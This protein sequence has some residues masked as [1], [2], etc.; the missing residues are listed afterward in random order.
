M[1]T[2]TQTPA[3]PVAHA[4]EPRAPRAPRRR[5]GPVVARVAEPVLAVLAVLAAAFAFAPFFAGWTWLVPVLVAAGAGGTLGWFVT[6]QRWP[7]WTLAPVGVAA[8][9]VGSLYGLHAS[10]TLY[11]LP[12]PAALR[13]TVDGVLSGWARMLTVALPADV[14]PETLALPVALVLVC[15]Y[16]AVLLTLRTRLVVGVAMPALVVL[17]GALALTAGRSAWALAATVGFLGAVLV[18]VLVRAN[19][20]STDGGDV[21]AAD[22][23]AVGVDLAAQRRHSTA[24]RVLFGLPGAAVVVALAVLGASALPLA[25]GSARVDPRTLYVP[26]VDVV[27]GLSPLVELQPQLAASETD[28]YVVRVDGADD[29]PV[30]RIRVAA[31]DRFDGALWTQDGEFV[32]AGTQ[33]PHVTTYAAGADPVR[34][35][36]EVLSN[37]SRFLPTVGEPTSL[38]DVDAAVDVTSG[39]LVRTGNDEETP[40]SYRLTALVADRAGIEDAAPPAGDAGLVGLP[41]VPEWVADEAATSAG[42]ATSPWAQLQAIADRLFALPYSAGAKPGHSY[43]A[44]SRTLRGD[45]PEPG[46]AEQ[47]ASAFAVLARSL[48]YPSR[49]AVGYRLDPEHLTEDGYQVTTKDAH[50]WP[51]VLLAGYGWVAFEPTDTTRTADVPADEPEVPQDV[52]DDTVAQPTQA[53]DDAARTGSEAPGSVLDTVVRTGV[54]VVAGLVLLVLLVAGGV[55][56]TKALRRARRRSHGTPA[57][58]VAAAWRETSD[59]LRENGVPVALAR[60]PHEVAEAVRRTGGAAGAGADPVDELA[61]VVTATVCAPVEPTEATARRAW[62]LEAETRR[63]VGSRLP[64]VRRVLSYVDPRSL[65]PPRTWA[66][67]APDPHPAGD[68]EVTVGAGRG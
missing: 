61:D 60:T 46:S 64:A 43:G 24:G 15:S 49:V 23:R 50:A 41:E 45:A 42:T 39:T 55:A 47:Y 28:L 7:A 6:W 66:G 38:T 35:E 10:R 68:D 17:L 25:D 5:W 20:T 11:G 44:I 16:S 52:P 65:R 14:G 53:D 31:L 12:V 1:A 2:S 27:T 63:R 62:M 36:V 59:L 22:A 32:L 57:R 56:L 4:P 3:P 54:L 67:G 9:L 51:E 40:L 13:D 26:P 37:R 58:R 33:L 19:R 48:G 34:L 8:V 18:L 21:S 29:V 30:D